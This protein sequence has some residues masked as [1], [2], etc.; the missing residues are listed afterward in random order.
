MQIIERERERGTRKA[1]CRSS[2]RY[3]HL[4]N[5]VSSRGRIFHDAYYRAA[6]PA[7][8]TLHFCSHGYISSIEKRSRR[9]HFPQRSKNAGASAKPPSSDGHD[10]ALVPQREIHDPGL[11]S[12]V[13]EEEEEE[14][15]FRNATRYSRGGKKNKK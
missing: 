5:C 12:C 14:F 11:I 3:S 2:A 10:D 8:F 13:G 6:F 7:L 9:G 1:S 15:I 4:Q